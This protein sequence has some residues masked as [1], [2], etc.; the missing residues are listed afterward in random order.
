MSNQST[1]APIPKPAKRSTATPNVTPELRAEIVKIPTTA[2][3]IRFLAS[4]G[5]GNGEIAKIL[6]VRYQHV[7]NT[8]KSAK[9]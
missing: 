4:K 3:R 2:A 8:V 5:K 6:D 7:Y 9:K 1:F